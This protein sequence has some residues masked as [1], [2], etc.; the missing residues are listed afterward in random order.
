MSEYFG[1]HVLAVRQEVPLVRV[2]REH[3]DVRVR[4]DAVLHGYSQKVESPV[5]AEQRLVQSVQPA[6]SVVQLLV[7]DLDSG[8]ERNDVLE[9]GHRLVEAF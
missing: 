1:D 6:F 3:R 2:H 4:T 5:L 9:L 7:D 8:T